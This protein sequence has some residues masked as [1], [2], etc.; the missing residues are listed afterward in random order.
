MVVRAVDLL[1]ERISSWPGRGATSG[2]TFRA[3]RGGAQPRGTH[4]E[5]AGEGRNLGEH[6]SSWPGRGATSGNIDVNIDVNHDVKKAP[7]GMLLLR[8]AIV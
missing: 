8:N 3:G 5:L 6:I 2:N 1:G 7:T 4:F